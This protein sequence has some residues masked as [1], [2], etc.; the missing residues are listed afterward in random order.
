MSTPAQS[1]QNAGA[2]A[3]SCQWCILWNAAF[4]WSRID[5]D[6][7]SSDDDRFDRLADV[8]W[9]GELILSA[10]AERQTDCPDCKRSAEMYRGNVLGE[11][12]AGWRAA[13]W[14]DNPTMQQFMRA[15]PED[16][17]QKGV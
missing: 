12:Q 11:Q 9:D 2:D 7:Y 1:N 8:A 4:A 16:T 3:T 15:G 14:R 13:M 5:P 17:F 6:K 10:L